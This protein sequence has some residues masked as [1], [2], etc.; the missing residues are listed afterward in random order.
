M[1]KITRN[2]VGI[3]PAPATVHQLDLGD[4]ASAGIVVIAANSLFCQALATTLGQ[5]F[6]VLG[7]GSTLREAQQALEQHQP[8]LSL[9]VAD[10]PFP[11]AA[12]ADMCR[13]L[14]GRYPMTCALLVVRD[15]RPEDLVLAYQQ[16]AKG[17]LD[18]TI[19]VDQLINGLERLACGEVVM[20]PEILRDMMQARTR[21][22]EPDRGYQRLTAA[23]TRMLMLLSEGYTSKEIA[24][25][26]QSSSA[27]VNHHI[28]RASQQ[29]GA[30]HRTEAVARA[31][32]LG[33]IT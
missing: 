27:S 21:A 15:R 12:F 10:P 6:T 33:I 32:R 7:T 1:H 28:E 29:L 26:V 22:D 24:R 23:Q 3:Q 25:M 31:L 14:V 5:Q 13:I 18:M 4:A 20:Q 2:N 17:L 19:D 8:Q 9:L 30:R 16:G 11:R